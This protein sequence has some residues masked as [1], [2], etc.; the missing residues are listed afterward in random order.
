MGTRLT[1]VPIKQK[2]IMETNTKEYLL[3][4]IENVE[5]ELRTQRRQL[6]NLIVKYNELS[7]E[8]SMGNRPRQRRGNVTTKD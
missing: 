8:Q 1:T 7:Y 5:R 6:V 2:L 4:R 3:S